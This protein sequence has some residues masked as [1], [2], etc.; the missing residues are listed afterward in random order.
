MDFIVLILGLAMLIFGAEGIVRGSVSLAKHFQ[1][2][3]FA[4]GAVV[5]AAGTSLPELA[6]CIRAVIM[7]H[8]DIAVGAVVGSNI[9]NVALIMGT[10]TILCPILLITSNQSVSYTHLTLPTNREV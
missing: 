2:S 9:A 3:L 1:I 7:D 8:S 5:V 6:N 10:T 4:I